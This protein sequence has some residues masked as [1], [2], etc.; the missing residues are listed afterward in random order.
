M[1]IDCMKHGR[2]VRDVTHRSLKSACEA[3]TWAALAFAILAVY[4]SG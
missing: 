3:Q 4:D 1:M 2:G